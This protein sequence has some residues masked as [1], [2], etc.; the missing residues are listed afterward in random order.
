MNPRELQPQVQVYLAALRLLLLLRHFMSGAVVAAGRGTAGD[1][2]PPE[3][4]HSGVEDGWGRGPRRRAVAVAVAVRCVDGAF[5]AGVAGEPW[6][7]RL[8]VSMR[9]RGP[10]V[11]QAVE[12]RR[13]SGATAEPEERRRRRP[14]AARGVRPGVREAEVVRRKEGVSATVQPAARRGRSGRS[15]CGAALGERALALVGVL[16]AAQ[17]LRGVELTLAEVALE[18]ALLLAAARR[19][20]RRGRLLLLRH[21]YLLLP[22]ARRHSLHFRRLRTERAEKVELLRR[23]LMLL[24]PRLHLLLPV[25]HLQPR[26]LNLHG[27]GPGARSLVHGSGFFHFALVWSSWP[28][29]GAYL[30]KNGGAKCGDNLR[31]MQVHLPNLEIT[32]D[33]RVL[34]WWRSRS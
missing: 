21:H 9:V 24:L 27:R 25:L 7:G 15:R 13:S 29:L 17:R 12:R 8:P 32:R 19:R 22:L 31:G 11:V 4:G 1:A 6:H 33:H 23:R 34:M 16:V 10:P 14:A 3:P 26:S 28:G 20:R 18:R 2:S 5:G 30:Y